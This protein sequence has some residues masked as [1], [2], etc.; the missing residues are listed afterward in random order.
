MRAYSCLVLLGML[1]SGTG[2][3]ADSTAA[4]PPVKVRRAYVDMR[5]GQLHYLIAT[6]NVPVAQRKR[7]LIMFHQSPL[8]AQE[9]AAL[10]AQ[11]GSDRVTIAVDTP[12]QGYSDGPE[13]VPTI[14][15]YAAAIDEGLHR[16]GYDAKHPVDI[17]G[18]HTGAFIATELAIAEPAMV[19]RVI[20]SGVYIVPEERRLKAVAGLSRPENSV[21]FYDE[22]CRVIPLIEKY[23]AEQ[24]LDEA[25]WGKTMASSL[26]P[27]TRREY[28]HIAAFDYAKTAST[29]LPLLQQPV[30]LIALNDGIGEPTKDSANFIKHVQVKD[31]PNFKDGAW[32]T[33]ARELAETV[34]GFLN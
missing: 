14:M 8:S 34:R 33:H 29:R 19:K 26:L 7:P 6:P 17:L 10:T 27:V 4:A 5:Y 22:L 31:F 3:A 1:I 21:Q 2:Q 9:L 28:G 12:G 32:T 13:Q 25:V 18:N 16:L 15:D 11:M 23:Y 30:L 24:G 20:L